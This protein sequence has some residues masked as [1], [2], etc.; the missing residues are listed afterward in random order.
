MLVATKAIVLSSIK[1]GDNNLIVK[2]LTEKEGCKSYMLRGVLSSKKGKV[3]KSYFQPLSQVKII[4][5][6]NSKGNLN[7]IKE[8]AMGYT[9]KT[10]YTNIYKQSIVIFL[11][12]ILNS[13]LQEEEE[14]KPLFKYIETSLKWLD[15]HPD[16]ANFHL[17]F[18]LNLTRFLGF[19][20]NTNNSDLNYFD[21]E[22]GVFKNNLGFG[23]NTISGS[24]L[25]DFKTLLGTNFD[26]IDKIKLTAQKRHEVLK[27]LILYFKLH[28]NGVKSPKSLDVLR[29]VF[30]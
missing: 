13:A 25:F 23:K 1:Y 27:V 17:L 5:N 18:L 16:F 12:E 30:Q 14:N 10:N 26:V 7:S 6:H 19:Y 24:V 11:S 9:Y 21:L 22:E 28:L 2:C 15:L 29:A 8:V 20:P 3:R 4:A